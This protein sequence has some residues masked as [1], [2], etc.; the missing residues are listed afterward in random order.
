MHRPGDL[1]PRAATASS[2]RAPPRPPP[3]VR[4]PNHLLSRAATATARLARRRS[5]P[6]SAAPLPSPLARLDGGA[7]APS[8]ARLASRAPTV[9][10]RPA[11]V[12]LH[13]LAGR[14]PSAPLL[15]TAPPRLSLRRLASSRGTLPPCRREHPTGTASPF[16]CIS[17]FGPAPLPFIASLFT[18][19]RRLSPSLP[20]CSPQPSAC[21]MTA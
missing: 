5:L 17:T 8:V 20:R 15:Y 13:P 7:R 16:S 9:L 19:A 12:H 21:C 10:C 6:S 1:N 14:P 2:G 3:A 4:C 18:S 11:P